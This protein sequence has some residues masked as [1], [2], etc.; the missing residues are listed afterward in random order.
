MKFDD[1]KAII[2]FAIAK[3]K[4]AEEFYQDLS[5]KT[6]LSAS[7]DIFL[8]FARQEKKHQ[9]LLED[10]EQKDIST[11]MAQYDLHWIQDLKRSDYVTEMEYEN[12]MGYRDILIL[13]MKREEKA[14]RLYND[15]LQQSNRDEH[16]KLFQILCQEEAKHKLK[17][18]TMYDDYMAEMGD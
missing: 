9:E 10:M 13:A 1:I 2:D 3:E 15:L 11:D 8:E 18:E 4:E 6:S 16:K 5:K 14:L 17:L 12:S 7:K